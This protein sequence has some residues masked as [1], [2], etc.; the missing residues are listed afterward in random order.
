MVKLIF[1]ILFFLKATD[2]FLLALN[3]YFL[4]YFPLS[5]T[6]AFSYPCVFL[7][8]P[9]S[10]PTHLFPFSLSFVGATA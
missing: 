8:A 6:F 1:L 9:H 5:F 10:P 4:D 3:R 7:P 2:N